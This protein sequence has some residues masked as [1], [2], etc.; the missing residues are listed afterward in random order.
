MTLDR[1][2]DGSDSP[3]DILVEFSDG[4]IRLR[5]EKELVGKRRE[6]RQK[7]F[8]RNKRP[9]GRDILDATINQV[10]CQ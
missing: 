8:D 7:T 4:C 2:E 5:I 6:T 1:P 9:R 10:R 3:P